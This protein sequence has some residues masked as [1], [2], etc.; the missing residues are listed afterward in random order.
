MPR[1]SSFS[2]LRD[3][4]RFIGQDNGLAYRGG[5]AISHWSIRVRAGASIIDGDF[6]EDADDDTDEG[7]DNAKSLATKVR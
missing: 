5:R 4:T 2:G 3:E 7:D 6:A 1:S